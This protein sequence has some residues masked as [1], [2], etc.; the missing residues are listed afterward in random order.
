MK[1]YGIGFLG[2][3]DGDPVHR[4]RYKATKGTLWLLN[5]PF[6]FVQNYSYAL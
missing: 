6:G 3:P 1:V 5:G 4:R 2:D